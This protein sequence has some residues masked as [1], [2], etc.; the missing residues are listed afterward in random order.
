ME[1]KDCS[2]VDEAG[3]VV[4]CCCLGSNNDDSMK[5]Y[6]GFRRCLGG[7]SQSH[8]ARWVH[9][10]LILPIGLVVVKVW[11]E[12]ELKGGVEGLREGLE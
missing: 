5:G 11:V 7:Y 10:V 1:S 3:F 4:G 6:L 9:Y 2:I 8:V 12:L